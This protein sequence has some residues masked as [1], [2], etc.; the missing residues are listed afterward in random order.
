MIAGM[1]GGDMM[2][3]FASGA[4]GSLGGSA[5]QAVGGKFAQ[6]L[7]GTVG[8]SALA[9]GVGAELSGGDF[10]RGAAT[11]ATIGL[12][13]HGRHQAKKAMKNI[14]VFKTMKGILDKASTANE[15]VEDMHNGNRPPNET[16]MKIL[17]LGPGPAGL[18]MTG[19]EVAN[20]FKE[21]VIQPIANEVAAY[22]Q[23]WE[24]WLRAGMPG[25][26]YKFSFPK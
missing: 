10:W 4:L 7:V 3:G 12:L 18:L 14:K 1:T 20:L 11:G 26:G 16:M 5:F 23:Q 25:S 19:V 8:F 24:D 6:S 13:N 2:Q 21:Y 22:N 17:S 15:I 9:G